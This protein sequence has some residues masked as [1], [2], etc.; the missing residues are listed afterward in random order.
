MHS[1]YSFYVSNSTDL[2]KSAV[3][4]HGLSFLR[5]PHVLQCVCVGGIPYVYPVEGEHVIWHEEF[6]GELHHQTRRAV[7]P[8]REDGFVGVVG[9]TGEVL[10][11][12]LRQHGGQRRH[13]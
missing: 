5:D 9:Q 13:T 1:S 2:L 3:W 8:H 10:A 12:L 6:R 7:L 4:F 11:L